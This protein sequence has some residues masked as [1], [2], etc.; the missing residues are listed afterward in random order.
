MLQWRAATLR[1]RYDS[2]LSVQNMNVKYVN[3]PV[4]AVHWTGKVNLE[5]RLPVGSGLMYFYN[6]YYAIYTASDDFFTVTHITAN[7]I[8][9]SRTTF[10]R[11]GGLAV[12][13][14]A[15]N[16]V[17]PF[18]QIDF[19][20][21][22]PNGEYQYAVYDTLADARQSLVPQPE[23]DFAIPFVHPSFRGDTSLSLVRRRF[24]N[25]KDHTRIFLAHTESDEP[26]AFT[27]VVL[28]IVSD[29]CIFGEL[30]E[31]DNVVFQFDC[32]GVNIKEY[33]WIDHS[34][35]RELVRYWQQLSETARRGLYIDKSRHGY[36][37]MIPDN[38]FIE[39]RYEYGCRSG[40]FTATRLINGQDS[41]SGL[42]RSGILFN[43]AYYNDGNVVRMIDFRTEPLSAPAPLVHT[44]SPN[45]HCTLL[46]A[47][48]DVSS[49]A[50]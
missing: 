48:K 32:L 39:N 5:K 45:D 26:H 15:V 21:L 31:K 20:Y 47:R 23:A 29:M 11:E 8:V 12:H 34:T 33:R 16:V 13:L 7:N 42:L 37:V 49:L 35:G 44:I 18:E 27:S 22:I 1:G 28:A 40:P 50:I 43:T 36:D 9:A 2:P 38:Q 24:A 10:T 17:Q 30:L 19:F 6:K 46:T 25:N 14:T 4:T 41:A 3:L